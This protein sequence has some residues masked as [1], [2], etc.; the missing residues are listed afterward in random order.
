MRW[1][2]TVSAMGW[3]ALFVPFARAAD[4]DPIEIARRNFQVDKVVDSRAEITMTLVSESGARR[5]RS[6]ISLS[7]LLPNGIDRERVVRF[8]APAEVKGTATLLVEHADRDDDI[9]IYLPALRKVRR[10]VA[11][12][13]KD[14][15]VGTDF[16]YGDIIGH[17]VEDWS[18][19]LEGRE[20]IDGNETYVLEATPTSDAV[21]ETSGYGKR[22]LWV[23]SDNFVA[24][25]ASY[26]D[27]GGTLLKELEAADVRP[28]APATGKWQAFRLTMHNRQTG[29]RTELVF[30]KLD[31]GVGLRD[32]E[33]SERYLDKE[34]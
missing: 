25:K 1:A 24:V 6:T 7:K 18:Y 34:P 5:E 11:N 13:K 32:D 19:R 20:T 27:G 33:F 17:R 4:L 21:R 9:W 2:V 29:H 31:V 12:N 3:C 26:W 16:S 30:T 14:S 10:L 28:I 23:R 8:L 15:F 22:K